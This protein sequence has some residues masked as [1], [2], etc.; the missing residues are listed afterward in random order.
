MVMADFALPLK[1]S[2]AAALAM[3]STAFAPDLLGDGGR[4][5]EVLADEDD[6]IAGLDRAGALE[7]DLEAVGHEILFVSMRLPASGRLRRCA[8]TYS[9]IICARDHAGLCRESGAIASC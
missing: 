3:R 9:N 6:E 7:V 5:L 8:W 1:L 4:R 2:A